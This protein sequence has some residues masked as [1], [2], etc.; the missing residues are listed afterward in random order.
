MSIDPKL[1]SKLA[2]RALM[3]QSV[4]GSAKVLVVLGGGTFGR[5]FPWPETGNQ[6]VI[7]KGMDCYDCNWQCRHPSRRCLDELP[8]QAVLEFGFDVLQGRAERARN[9]GEPVAMP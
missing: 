1:N 2:A 8:W 9:L 3:V 7:F 5:F 4:A 6:F